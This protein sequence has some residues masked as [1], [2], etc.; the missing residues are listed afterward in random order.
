[1]IL[2]PRILGVEGRPQTGL[3]RYIDTIIFHVCENIILF[4]FVVKIMNVRNLQ[5]YT[6]R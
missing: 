6:I 2:H 1:M 5:N 4:T 3:F